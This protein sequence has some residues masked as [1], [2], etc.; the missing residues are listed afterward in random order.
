MDELRLSEL[1][2]PAAEHPRRRY[3]APVAVLVLGALSI[4]LLLWTH[5]TSEHQTSRQY[6]L[7]NAIAEAEV[8][9]ATSHLWLEEF[10][11]EDAYVDIEDKLADLEKADD[12]IQAVVQG[13]EIDGVLIEPFSDPALR[14]QATDL[15]QRL[16]EFKNLSRKRQHLGEEAG[17]GTQLDQEYDL[18]FHNLLDAAEE[19][20][21]A[22]KTRWEGQQSLAHLRLW[23]IVAA[24]TLVVAAA[25]TGL[26]TREKRRLQA[27]GALRRSQQWLATT[28]QSIGDGVITT[29]LQGAVTFMNPVAQK[30]TGWPSPEAS[31]K[32]IEDVF[33]IAEEAGE[34][35]AA[36]PVLLVIRGR[37]AGLTN[38]TLL[39]SRD[40]GRHFISHT[41]APIQ[42]DQFTLLGVVL[43]F[44]DMTRRKQAEKALRQRELELREA[45]KMEAV[46]RLAGGIAHDINNYLGAIRGY[47]EVAKMKGES[48]AA[49]E[50]RMDEA[51]ETTQNVSSL[52]KQ[53]LA[54]SR[55][56]PV[57]PEVVDLNHVV[58]G[59]ESMVQ[60]LIGEDIPLVTDLASDLWPI[61]IDPS[62]VE[63]ILVNLLVN[64]RDAMP[65]GG[66]IKIETRNVIP[67]AVDLDKHP[68]AQ[69]GHYALLSVADNG[70]GIESEVRE[71]IFEPFFTTKDDSGRSGLGLAT[72]YGIVQHSGGF[73]VVESELGEG[74]TFKVLL[75]SCAQELAAIREEEAAEE[76]DAVGP[77]RV[78]LVEDNAS[79]RAS[80]QEMLEALGHDV[81]VAADGEEALRRL[82]EGGEPADI[83]ITDVVMP[84]MSGKELADRLREQRPALRCLFI[85]GYTGEV[86]GKHGLN[87]DRLDFLAKPFG[88]SQLA[89]K[90]SEMMSLPP[91]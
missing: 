42:V 18:V 19:L 37:R 25:A 91:L 90:I 59:L 20:R 7:D 47:C 75:P 69:A 1:I 87:E 63:Q 83:V 51:I 73:I 78:F 40:G 26:W 28:L 36:N 6:L 12:S 4:A 10:L 44:R 16:T 62:Q 38:H 22:L 68:T 66:R 64:A 86:M 5:Q 9:I 58:R 80:T 3:M 2:E 55:R 53:L 32:P 21:S 57:E 52:I 77:L 56:Q 60:R 67:D 50:R 84:G 54:F 70:A 33:Q 61:E 31:G 29:D 81:R 45:Q 30:L 43:V 72:V 39:L 23:A 34:H 27:G 88:A 82:V 46:G 85:S 14:R 8:M 17:I 76:V 74:T 41:A 65:T 48:G 71:K 35:P 13:G 79:M 49:L 89:R 15:K 24:W 11:T